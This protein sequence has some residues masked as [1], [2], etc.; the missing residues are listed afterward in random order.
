MLCIGW[1]LITALACMPAAAQPGDAARYLAGLPLPE[2]S[3]YQSLVDDE[4]QSY[5]ESFNT[6]WQALEQ[7]RFQP[8]RDWQAQVLA[9]EILPDLPV[10]YPFGGP[11]MIHALMLYPHSQD[12]L[13]FGLEPPGSLELHPDATPEERHQL[14]D[15]VQWALRDI[16]QRGYFIT[17]RMSSDLNRRELDG[18]LPLLLVFIARGGYEVLAIEHGWLLPDGRFDT[19]T[20]E[21]LSRGLVTDD[22]DASP[23]ESRDPRPA[24]CANIP[25]VR[26]RFRANDNSP[27][28]QVTYLRLDV[29]DAGLKD[30]R[31]LETYVTG[32]G[33]TNTFIKSASYL[34]H[35][36]TFSR[37]RRLTLAVSDSVF[38]DDTGIPYR[39]FDQADWDILLFGRY[40]TPI[41]DFSGVFQPDLNQAYMT[42]AHSIDNL[43]FSMGYHWWTSA[44]NHLIARRRQPLAKPASKENA[45]SLSRP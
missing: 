45:G 14:L 17:G 11:D 18:V 28:K 29:S 43:P 24:D 30:C 16:Y 38:Q 32:L 1:I 27:E 40:T 20:S 12:Y 37:V 33:P 4:W 25:G 23:D 26:V 31:A 5:Q 6:A 7:D 8:M 21:H 19:N 41:R 3:T 9:S 15:A 42:K 34:L 36:A 22:A 44:Q 39:D 35:Y 2:H 10:Y 13:L